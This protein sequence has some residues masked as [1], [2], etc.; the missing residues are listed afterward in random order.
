M[1]R[2]ESAR[3]HGRRQRIHQQLRRRSL[4][5]VLGICVVGLVGCGGLSDPESIAKQESLMKSAGQATSVVDAKK[6]EAW[7]GGTAWEVDFSKMEDGKLDTTLWNISEGPKEANYNGEAQTYSGRE[8]NVRIEDGNLVIQSYVEDRDGKHYTS[9]RINTHGKFDFKHG[10]IVIVAKL[11]PGVGTWPAAWLMPSNPRYDPQ[12]L[13]VGKKD[14]L[15]W[16]VNGE[17]DFMESIGRLPKEIHPAAH[18]YNQRKK[19]T[20]Y[21]PGKVKT[22]YTKFHRYGLIKKPGVIKFTIDGKVYATRKQTSTDPLWWPF[23]Q[24]YYLIINHA[25]GGPWAGSETKAFPPDGIDRSKEKQ[26]KYLIR[27]ITY[28]PLQ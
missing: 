10:K 14:P 11:P 8:K 23:E 12:K 21:T 7:S 4:G 5:L 19:R 17:I 1:A 3:G 28:K 20:P 22:P 13:G 26:W 18:T 27:K 9:A 15:A 16:V 24:N 2:V 25:L 6:S